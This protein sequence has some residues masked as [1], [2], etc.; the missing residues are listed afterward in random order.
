MWHACV[1]VHVHVCGMHACM[2]VHVC[3][4][5]A[6]MYMYVA[7]MRV[8]VCTCMW[9]AC[10]YVHVCIMHAYR[11]GRQPAV[12]SSSF[13]SGRQHF[14]FCP[15]PVFA[16]PSGASA[17]VA[18]VCVCVCVRSAL[19]VCVCV[20]VCACVQCIV[21]VCAC[22]CVCSALCVCVCACV[23]VCVCECVY[24][25]RLSDTVLYCPPLHLTLLLSLRL[26]SHSSDITSSA[27]V[28]Y[29]CMYVMRRLYTNKL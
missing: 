19:C 13:G 29:M 1:Y 10:V 6:C 21:C 28:T 25:R 20:H 4:M 7:C 2:Y 24:V 16:A 5:H 3:G 12:R 15:T 18:P 23:H 9:Y 17:Q 14:S 8:H 11:W 27:G 26:C 22:M